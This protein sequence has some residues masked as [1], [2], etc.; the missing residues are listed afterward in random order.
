MRRRIGK[1]LVFVRDA[2]LVLCVTV[3]YLLLLEGLLSLG[4]LAADRIRDRGA[5]ASNPRVQADAHAD[6][7]WAGE[8]YREL[9]ESSVTQWVSYVYWRRR[10]YQGRFIH[11]DADGIRRTWAPA[12]QYQGTEAPLRIFLFGGSAMWGVGARD[13]Y[14]IPSCLAR[15]LQEQ[16]IACEATNFGESGYV[17][18]Q[19]VIALLQELRKGNVPDLVIFYDGVND[20]YSAYQQQVAGLPQNEFHRAGEFN[21]SQPRGYRSLRTLFIRRAADNL[22][23]VRLSRNLLRKAGISAGTEVRATHRAVPAPS[24]D[25]ESLCREILAV[26]EANMKTVMTLAEAHGFKAL[27]YWQ[28]TVFNRRHPTAYERRVQE[29]IRDVQPYC[30]RVGELIRRETFVTAHHE[31]FE[32]ISGLFEEVRAPVFVDWC[33]VS[34]W[35]NE[36]IARRMAADVV[37]LFLSQPGAAIGR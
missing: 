9:E 27:F 28:P 34:E 13:D 25:A 7:A 26:Y 15:S 3:L 22:A 4:Y 36:Q 1:S 37:R 12:E 8:Y 11:V 21:L 2:W 32:D 23:M 17:S 6:A 20:L 30:R 5:V 33:H 14:T 18:T 19:E 10:A 31:Y 29:E 16:R 35:G 24:T